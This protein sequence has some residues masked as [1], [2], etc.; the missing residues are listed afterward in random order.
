MTPSQRTS[1][2]WATA[3]L[4]LA[5]LTCGIAALAADLAFLGLIAGIL[6]V[7]AGAAGFAAATA[8]PPGEPA[9]DGERRTS[10]PT[11][12]AANVNDQVTGLRSEEYFMAAAGDRIDAARRYLRP[13][14]LMLLEI[15]SN[16]GTTVGL[17]EAG[18]TLTETLR[19]ADMIC[20]R[21]DDSFA[22]LLEDTPETGARLVVERLR[23]ALRGRLGDVVVHAGVAC[24]P[25]HGLDLE[26][27]WALA[28]SALI[29]ALRSE[30]DSTAVADAD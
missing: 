20:R 11:P 7:G 14:A 8:A 28:E 10:A 24:Y 2:G 4:G 27:I 16:N 5:G 12:P 21:Q 25:A 15:R 23:P 6:A 3:A 22:I 9:S 30:R 19:E 1:I 29:E 18:E 26:A 13:V 17:K